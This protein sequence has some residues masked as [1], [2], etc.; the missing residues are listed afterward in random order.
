M[1]DERKDAIKK[2]ILERLLKN[3]TILSVC[4]AVG[5]DRKTFYRWIEEDNEFKKVAYE[6][7]LES[8][9]DI[10]DMAYTRLVNHIS[11]GNLTAIMYW[12]NNKDPTLNNKTINMNKDEMKKLL[13]LLYNPKTFKDGQELLTL[14]VLQRNISESNAQLILKLFLANIKVDD[15]NI[16]KTESEI[17]SEVLLR[18]KANKLRRK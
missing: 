4:N 8:K 10:T 14:H 3:F 16:R 12:L 11:E 7:I 18:K 2:Q 1:T 13:K 15:I 17:I 6:N 5:I 9:K